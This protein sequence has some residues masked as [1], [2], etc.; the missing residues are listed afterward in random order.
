LRYQGLIQLLG[1]SF[2]N[3]VQRAARHAL[4]EI[5]EPAI[6]PLIKAFEHRDRWAHDMAGIT[7]AEIGI[8]AVEQLIVALGHETKKC[9]QMPPPPWE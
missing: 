4:A 2:P 6:V 7:L 9:A 3:S 5:G 8:P 1:G